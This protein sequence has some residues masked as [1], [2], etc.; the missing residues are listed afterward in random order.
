MSD[1]ATEKLLTD[2]QRFKELRAVIGSD[3]NA[4]SQFLEARNVF[5]TEHE[6]TLLN[7]Q[8]FVRL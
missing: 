8:R 2:S 6:Q 4:S 5:A 7:W 3:K 1:E